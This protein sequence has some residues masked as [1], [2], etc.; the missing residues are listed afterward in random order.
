MP[1]FRN[2]SLGVLGLAAAAVLASAACQGGT[3]PTTLLTPAQAIFLGEA[4]W[5]DAE[6]NNS[7]ATI[8]GATAVY[9]DAP[10]LGTVALSSVQCTP[11]TAPPSPANADAD[12]IKDSVRFTFSST[13]VLNYP[14]E[15]DTLRGIMDNLDPTPAMAD[16]A[17][18]RVFL[19]LVKARL[20]SGKLSYETWN[21]TR[22]ANWDPNTL[23]HTETNFQT[24]YVFPDGTAATHLRSWTS[25][26]TADVAGTIMADQTL[27]SGNWNIAGTASWMQGGNT[28]SL[29]LTTTTA[30]HYNASCTATPR[31]DAGTLTAAVTKGTQSGTVTI[32]F[33]TC[34]SVSATT[35]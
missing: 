19:G 1:Q 16:N 7:N 28:Y 21:G 35:A 18:K 24:Q 33:L 20:R 2:S 10:P 31:F 15:S 13:C 4:V 8:T 22:M 27:P 23:S 34:G 25:N 30:L 5:L 3:A 32:K 29:T 11:S 6:S 14:A 26:F 12:A 9:N 17:V